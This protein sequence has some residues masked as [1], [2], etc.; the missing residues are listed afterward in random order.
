MRKGLGTPQNR[1]LAYKV[2]ALFGGKNVH[3][4]LSRLDHAYDIS[5]SARTLYQWK[6]EGGWDKRLATGQDVMTFNELT[7]R[8]L[9]RI[10]QKHERHYDSNEKAV[11]NAQ[12]AYA[13]TNL[14][15]AALSV[16]R[17][18]ELWESRETGEEHPAEEK[19]AAMV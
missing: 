9:N 19:D 2:F 14:V 10:I 15:K 3:K 18:M 8:R 13:Y 11:G 4:I 17:G 5:M 1:E 16:S 12:L 6:D 7:L